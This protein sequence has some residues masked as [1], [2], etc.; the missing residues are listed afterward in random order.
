[1]SNEYKVK[2]DGEDVTDY[3]VYPLNFQFTLDDAL[4]Q[5]YIE[6]RNS[7][8]KEVYKPFAEVGITV[9]NEEP[10]I[11]YI[12]VDNATVN[13]KNG[14][15]T[16]K[17]LLIEETKILERVIC[18][19][20]T[21]VKPLYSDYF[22]GNVK[23]YPQN[24]TTDEVEEIYLS[25]ENYYGGKILK[26]DYRNCV[27]S[28]SL[29]DFFEANF[30]TGVV[31]PNQS[32][33]FSNIIKIND[34]TKS[35]NSWTMERVYI[36]LFCEENGV[37]QRVCSTSDKNSPYVIV[38]K[39][40]IYKINAFANYKYE[41]TAGSWKY[42][43]FAV[44][45]Q[46]ACTNKVEK[47]SELYV[48]DIVNKLLQVA[49]P[50]RIGETPRF[51]LNENDALKYEKTPCSEL[52]FSNGASLWENLLEVGKIIHCIPRLK[53][54]KIY[55]DRLGESQEVKLSDFGSPIS[56]QVDLSAEKF[57]SHIDS[58]VDGLINLDN[59]EQ[60]A[61]SDPF[62]GGWRTLRS[63]T[64]FTDMR[65]TVNSAVIR[66]VKPIEKIAKLTC[67]YQNTEYDIT[68][69]IYEKNE[70]DLL[71]SNAGTY[72][73]AK[74]YAI[75][76]VQ[77]KN[78]IFGL[79][80]KEEDP[81]SS[82]FKKWSIENILQLVSG[83]KI[84]L[85]SS[86]S[87][88]LLLLSFNVS[89]ITVINGRVRQAKRNTEDL[90]V[91]S[92]IAFNQSANRLSS[93]NFG[94]RL[95]GEIAMLGSEETKLVFKTKNWNAVRDAVGRIY[96]N[97]AY[98][99]NMYISNVT[100]KMWRDYWLVELGLTKNFNQLGRFVGIN[101]QVRQF[102]ID[103]NVS[104][105]Y[106]LDEEYLVFSEVAGSYDNDAYINGKQIA[107][108][109]QAVLIG[110]SSDITKKISLAYS[111]T[112]SSSYESIT[113]TFHPVQS[114]ALGNSL[115]FNYTYED[116]YSA[117]EYLQDID[118]EYK[119]TRLV[120]YGEPI[121]GEAAY[122]RFAFFN[123]V[124][125]SDIDKVTLGDSLPLIAYMHKLSGNKII[126]NEGREL[127]VHKSSRDALN[128]TYQI[129]FVTDCGIIFGEQF[130]QANPLV[131]GTPSPVYKIQGGLGDGNPVIN[132]YSERVNEMT[133]DTEETP[134]AKAGLNYT[135]YDTFGHL[136]I[137]GNAP[138]KYTSW[139]VK[140]A[141]G[142]VLIAKNGMFNG[143]YYY[144]KRKIG[145]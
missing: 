104:E 84:N 62:I 113:A 52:N 138:S 85:E 82:I 89:Y 112:I 25:N 71:Y 22:K 79:T 67:C 20:K 96:P 30:I 145:G 10:I 93:I 87:S 140:D 70:Y 125:F 4:D 17:I 57:A 92:V 2:I 48:T 47:P 88:G 127:V 128:I 119:L 58:V 107:H 50:I 108:S 132:F 142:R 118:K 139:N 101:S 120:R 53:N 31:T 46:I 35:L 141:N 8:R 66:T 130:M 64:S 133:G 97:T 78:D 61:I 105:S 106:L 60:G 111:H 33:H 117:G 95:K 59:E 143:L 12:G 80:Y 37:Q 126:E 135:V 74:A 38:K 124:A 81:V 34:N 9:N 103:T 36:E 136:T 76:Y 72:P 56:R 75:Y 91:N 69:Y 68:P 122:L 54:K 129:H 98:G 13:Q 116:N 6:I 110:T 123:C 83:Q 5:A 65:T 114:I 99:N 137:Y 3:V 18:R 63:E 14:L 86:G 51:T 16:H 7:K 27:Y 131:G 109:V 45:Y 41:I 121:Y 90:K 24:L 43:N 40:G 15:A 115:L 1:M 23:A 77:G 39:E 19:A 42:V 100:A 49:E 29:D 26:P 144:T 32:I 55:F 102:E 73:Y 21:F 94:K 11:Y 28:T 44:S 134:I